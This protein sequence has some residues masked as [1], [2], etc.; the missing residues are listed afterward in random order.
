MNGSFIRH[1]YCGE[2]KVL[3]PLP[4]NELHPSALSNMNLRSLEEATDS[5]L[6]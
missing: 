2:T 6:S 1:S 4:F 3:L 5:H